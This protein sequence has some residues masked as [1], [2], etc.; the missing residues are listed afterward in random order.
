VL[1]NRR[2]IHGRSPYTPRHDGHDRWLQRTFV[3]QTPPAPAD[4]LGGS[5]V[6]TGPLPP[7]AG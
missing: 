5:H 2:V 1:D 6:V 7:R 3:V 4:L